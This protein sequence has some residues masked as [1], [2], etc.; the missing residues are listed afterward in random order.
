MVKN[1]LKF[2]LIGAII[3]LNSLSEINAQLSDEAKISILTSSPG[4]RLYATF[5]HTAIRVNDPINEIDMI[6]NY[7]TFDF[8]TQ[9]FYLK[10]AR[11]KLN[12]TLTI[13]TFE[14]FYEEYKYHERS[15][16]EQVLSLSQ[17]EKDNLY[18][19]LIIN[20]LPENRYYLYDFFYDNCAT[21]VRDMITN[22][23]AS[24][25][26]F[27]L[28]SHLEKLTF[29]NCI[30]TYLEKSPWIKLGLDLILGKP[31]DSLVNENTIQFLP[32]YLMSSFEVTNR[33]NS[34][35]PIVESTTTIYESD[36]YTKKSFFS[37]LKIL[38]I[39][40]L[41]VFLISV[42]DFRKNKCS[43]WLDILLF[44][45]VGLLGLLIIFLWFF[46]NHQV[47]GPNWHILWANP[48]LI[49]LLFLKKYNSFFKYLI[50]IIF[51]LQIYCLIFFATFKQYIPFEL[52]PIWVMMIIRIFL[53]FTE[54]RHFHVKRK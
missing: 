46:T 29:R 19:A 28:P 25:I 8:N 40:C 33:E 7:G 18:N 31:T 16:W 54:V 6:F 17:I 53:K 35:I 38:V 48:L 51:G 13:E 43:K 11:G 20:A 23:L 12:Y 45:T 15:I 30:A 34:H 27:H 41:L 36:Q 50:G 32:D 21:R 2:L 26:K 1:I 37:P 39:L 9:Y 22:N 47:T 49:I 52:I 10:F 24:P 14:H 5:G 42:Y 4:K 44:T 3:M